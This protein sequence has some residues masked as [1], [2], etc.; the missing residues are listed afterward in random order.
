MPAKMTHLFPRLV[1][2]LCLS[3][4]AGYAVADEDAPKRH[5]RIAN[6][7][8]YID[9]DSDDESLPLEV[10]SP[11]L[12]GFA[13]KFNCTV[14]YHEFDSPL[15]QILKFNQLGGFYDIMVASC[16]FSAT[17]MPLNVIMPFDDTL[18]PNLR[19][20]DEEA[21]HPPPDMEGRF[22]I[23]YLEGYHGLAFRKDKIGKDTLTWTE[24][25]DPP[26]SW[27]EHIGILDIPSVIFASAVI[28]K[29]GHF[30]TATTE[31]LA[32][33]HQLIANLFQNYK[34]FVSN[35]PAELSRKLLSGEIWVVPLATPDGQLLMAQNKD[36]NLAFVIP[37]EGSEYYVDYFII[38]RHSQN[39]ETA[40]LFI[41]Y[42]LEPEN[43]G[44]IAAYLGSIAPSA[45]ARE[46]SAA[47]SQPLVPSAVDENGEILEHLQ[48]FF[49]LSP[50]IEARWLDILQNHPPE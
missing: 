49:A 41:N 8:S 23:P 5:L 38:N 1:L 29:G 20:L 7:S 19:L 30:P 2:L 17:I 12:R 43:L 21:R 35:D 13:E 26:E 37:E 9:L 50:E 14:E 44:R 47:H 42:V 48:V 3:M 16:N 32:E 31:E 11:T 45:A 24:Y 39:K 10:R 15:N 36:E 28:S 4:A 34:P 22:L 27:K 40:H 6:W 46:V 25:F 33:A 18:I